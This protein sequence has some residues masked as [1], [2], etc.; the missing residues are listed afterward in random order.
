MTKREALTCWM[1]ETVIVADGAMGTVLTMRGLPLGSCIP[2]AN[3]TQAE[4]VFALHRE[5]VHAG[6]QILTSNTF[7]A[8]RLH[9]ATFDL[10][11]KV[12][13]IN[14]RGVEIARRAAHGAPVW[15]GA[16]IGPLKVML[17]PYGDM[18]E[19]E[20]RE[21]CREQVEAL[22]DAGPDLFMLETQQSVLEAMFFMDACREVAA[23]ADAG[24][25]LFILET[26][27][28]VL[29]AMFFMDACSNPVLFT[30]P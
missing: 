1:K 11:H 4:Q 20:A 10:Q 6:A 24:P 2:E 16:C 14:A 23:L 15:V 29:E 21:I 26:Q 9:L 27:Q 12:R 19:S 28:S 7:K 25:D 30:I 5:Y 17:K 18:D 22:A 8:H 3:L 13:D